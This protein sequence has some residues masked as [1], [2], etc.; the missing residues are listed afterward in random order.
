MG[1]EIVLVKPSI[2]NNEDTAIK[3]L[4][5]RKYVK[6]PFRKGWA[7]KTILTNETS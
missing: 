6:W 2:Q 1:V 7:A 4:K 3:I 5:K